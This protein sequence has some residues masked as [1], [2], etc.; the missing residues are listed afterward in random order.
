MPRP[1]DGRGTRV[2]GGYAKNVLVLELK[3][4][5]PVLNACVCVCV[6]VYQ[7]AQE[8]KKY[9]ANGKISYLY[10]TQETRHAL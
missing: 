6:R 2:S 4:A 3:R 10:D 8:G 1:A 9:A 7:K 5:C